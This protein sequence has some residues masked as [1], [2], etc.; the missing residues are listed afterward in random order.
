MS[1]GQRQMH[2]DPR[3]EDSTTAH[4]KKDDN[5]WQFCIS[6]MNISPNVTMA[7]YVELWE[8]HQ[9]PGARQHQEG[10]RDRSDEGSHIEQEQLQS[11]ID[12]TEYEEQDI[13]DEEYS[14]DA[15]DEHQ[16]RHQQQWASNIGAWPMA[17]VQPRD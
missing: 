13:D 2:E 3:T 5:T 4:H 8:D 10:D 9:Y 17:P 12:A 15:P 7:K 11:H 14:Q 1:Q 6:D 16:L